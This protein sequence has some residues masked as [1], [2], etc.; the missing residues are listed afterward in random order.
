MT[1]GPIGRALRLARS[2]AVLAG[3]GAVGATLAITARHLLTTPQPLDSGLPGAGRIDRAHGGE[4]YYTVAGPDDAPPLVLLHDFY[5][6]ASNYEYRRLFPRLTDS[7]R[8][9]APDWLGWGMSERPAV[10]YTGEFYAGTL[11]GFLRDV[12]GQPALVVAHGRSAGIAVRAASDGPDLFR[13]LALVAP[14]LDLEAVATPTLGQTAARLAQRLWVGT[15]PY[16]V[17]SARAMLRWQ[18]ARRTARD[19]DDVSRETVNH[20]YASSHQFGGEH[21]ASALLSGELD[22]PIGNAFALL[23]TPTLVLVGDRDAR[24][25]VDAMRELTALNRGVDVVV[26]P[27]ATERVVEDEPFQLAEELAQWEGLTLA[28]HPVAAALA[29]RGAAATM[30]EGARDTNGEVGMLDDDTIP[31]DSGS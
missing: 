16:A 1:R 27:D 31:S 7:Y 29:E 25:P 3:V 19:T 4:L 12:V 20:L 8:V 23:E 24:H 26:I 28:P 6:G 10:A 2:A 9:Y 15:V 5:I 30:R 13:R 14:T 11:R 22:L 17:L 18:A 21:A